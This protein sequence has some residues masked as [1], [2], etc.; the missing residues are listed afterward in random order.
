MTGTSVTTHDIEL[1]RDV[2]A[3]ARTRA[4]H[5]AVE[6]TFMVLDLLERLLHSDFV[7]FQDMQVGPGRTIGRSY[8][9][10]VE[11]GAHTTMDAEDLARYDRD[12][13]SDVMDEYWWQLPCSLVDRT[14]TAQVS[15]LRTY[16][17]EREWAVHPVRI[18]YLT[19]ADE[20][21]LAYPMDAGR[22]LRVLTGREEGPAYGLR[23]L[24][25]MELLLPH[26]L[27]LLEAARGQAGAAGTGL[28]GATSYLTQRQLEILRL[29][30]LGMG[31]RQVGRQLSISEGTVRK[32]LEN[33]YERLGVQSRTEAIFSLRGLERSAG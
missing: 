27:P 32:H 8:L 30:T 20:I 28:T 17:G 14:G 23:E 13:P 12:N 25:L 22:S 6:A 2:V 11:G 5:G 33:A 24:T 7:S 31:N 16:F 19:V 18:D 3:L 1:L 15:S 29:V 4:D 26:L 9:Q 21:L 10:V